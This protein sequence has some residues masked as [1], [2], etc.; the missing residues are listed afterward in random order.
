MKKLAILA[1]AVCMIAAAETP[2]RAQS[3]DEERQAA[4]DTLREIRIRNSGKHSKDVIILTYGKD[5]RDLV[6]VIDKGKI[7]SEEDFPKYR[8]RLDEALGAREIDEI[9]PHLEE[10]ERIIESRRRTNEEKIEALK[11]VMEEL[12][13]RETETAALARDF[14]IARLGALDAKRLALE[15][16][17][18]VDSKNHLT[19]RI[20][21]DGCY[22]NGKKLPDDLC[23]RLL[24]IRDE[25]RRLPEDEDEWKWFEER[26]R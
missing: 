4:R 17:I 10:L 11:E 16:W 1:A 8:L 14:Y 13:N 15:P 12:K 25:S 26:D 7:V 19:I 24:E 20:R 2:A 22:L 6:S 3:S 21:K 9:R 18:V 5:G 23:E